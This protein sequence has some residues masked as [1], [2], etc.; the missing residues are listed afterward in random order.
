MS[1]GLPAGVTVETVVT[2]GDFAEARALFEEYAEG[3][4]VDLCFQGFSQ[5]LERMEQMYAAPHGSLLLARADGRVVGCVAMRPF[6]KDAPCA[7]GACGSGATE[8]AG[9]GDAADTRADLS[10]LRVPV[11]EMKRLY[12]RPELRGAQLGRRLA[13]AIVR[14]AVAKGY[15]TMVL[16]TLGTMAAAQALYRSLGFREIEPYY[17]NSLGQVAFMA[18]DLI[19][20]E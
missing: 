6:R 20:A 15:A 2:P 13:V 16:D 3:L 10:A 4:G 19:P 9:T 17:E 12:V 7:D 14:E 1:D 18:L 5:E 11:C 8:E